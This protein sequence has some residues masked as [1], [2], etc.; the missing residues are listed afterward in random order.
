MACFLIWLVFCNQ[1]IWRFT[2]AHNIKAVSL[3]DYSAYQDTVHYGIDSFQPTGNLAETISCIGWAFAETRYDN[4][5]SW[6]ELILSNDKRCYSMKFEFTQV[7]PD[8]LEAFPN[9]TMYGD[10]FGFYGEFPTFMMK[11]GVY[12]V[13]IC[14]WENEY[15]FG[16]TRINYQID[17]KGAELTLRNLAA[18]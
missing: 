1:V 3:D 17:K 5:D 2:G 9:L 10:E 14:R 7:R 15:N 16:I 12:D 6:T 11:S 18:N 4:S 13:Y 8:L